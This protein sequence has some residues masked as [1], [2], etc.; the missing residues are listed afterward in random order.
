MSLF[1]RSVYIS[2]GLSL[3]YIFLLYRSNPLRRLP[4]TTVTLSF[5][6]GMCAVVPVVLF[7]RL[8]PLEPAASL[9]SAYVNAGL[10]EEGIKFLVL[11]G[12]I[13]WLG[14]P[15]LA[16]PID[17]VVYL[18]VLG[19]GFGI[20]EDFWY[21]FSGSYNVWIDGDVGRFREVFSAIVLAR[22]FPG[23]ILFGGIAGCLVGYARF[24]RT[25]RARLPWLVGGFVLAVVLHGTFNVIASAGGTIPLLAYWSA[26]LKLDTLG[27]KLIHAIGPT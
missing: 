19:A 3:L 24:L 26:P 12:T 15:D 17:F 10:V 6:V 21:I 2:S 27:P 18:G 7:R 5:A 8:F 9:F 20:Y 22:S 25:W 1:L 16:E 4:G 11:A 23:H 14:F 13:W